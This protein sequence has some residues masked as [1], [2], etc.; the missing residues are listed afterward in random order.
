MGEQE[1]SKTLLKVNLIIHVGFFY[2]KRIVDRGQRDSLSGSSHAL[3][4]WGLEFL[5]RT[6]C[7]P[8]S[9]PGSGLVVV[10]LGHLWMFLRGSYE[11]F[12]SNIVWLQRQQI[13]DWQTIYLDPPLNP[14]CTCTSVPD[15]HLN[16]T[17]KNITSKMTQRNP[18]DGFGYFLCCPHILEAST[19]LWVSFQGCPQSPYLPILIQIVQNT[20]RDYKHRNYWFWESSCIKLNYLHDLSNGSFLYLELIKSF[21]LSYKKVGIMQCL[22]PW[23]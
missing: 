6:M 1:I 19:R 12:L 9:V 21:F 2:I 13:S 18:G 15:Q 14:K 5:S 16:S 8:P 23:T 10:E 20:H 4:V 7:L 11:R 17:L 22:I 3:Y